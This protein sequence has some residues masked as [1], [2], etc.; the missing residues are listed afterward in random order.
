MSKVY[1][2]LDLILS[3]S[4]HY[5]NKVLFYDD[6]DESIVNH[7]IENIE[8]YCPS[9]P[10]SDDEE[11][12]SI[13]LNTIETLE[14]ASIAAKQ[15]SCDWSNRLSE[16][17]DAVIVARGRIIAYKG[18]WWMFG[19]KADKGQLKHG[20]VAPW[21]Y[22]TNYFDAEY[23]S[24]RDNIDRV[25]NA[26]IDGDLSYRDRS[27]LVDLWVKDAII[28]ES[29]KTALS[30][31]CDVQR[32]FALPSCFRNHPVF[33]LSLPHL[34]SHYRLVSVS[35][36]DSGLLVVKGNVTVREKWTPGGTILF[37]IGD[38][39]IGNLFVKF[40]KIETSFT[41]NLGFA[42][43]ALNDVKND[44]DFSESRAFE[45]A[46]TS[47]NLLLSDSDFLD[48]MIDQSVLFDSGVLI[49]DDNVSLLETVLGIR[50]GLEVI[51]YRYLDTNLFHLVS[52][53]DDILKPLNSAILAIPE[54]SYYNILDEVEPE[55]NAW[56]GTRLYL[57]RYISLPR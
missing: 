12:K 33:E 57:D 30:K 53:L 6:I 51:L 1:T 43:S 38:D 8:L 45:I 16:F 24:N 42:V 46:K 9:H 54:D 17:L 34:G 48:N 28:K 49:E 31:R 27:A 39:I 36:D 10:D 35:N 18:S 22:I 11:T 19:A 5:K 32:I 37:D 13:W 44:P 3:L 47:I 29:Y 21:I 50:V 15:V 14:F 56:W 20:L 41:D 40:E 2:G 52:N 23:N 25:C 7:A 55:E 26:W 4:E